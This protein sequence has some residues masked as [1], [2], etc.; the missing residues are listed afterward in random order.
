MFD[1]KKNTKGISND[2]S[3]LLNFDFASFNINGACSLKEMNNGTFEY[4]VFFSI[5]GFEDP[6]VEY[7]FSKIIVDHPIK[8]VDDL[9]NCI[10]KR[11]YVTFNKNVITILVEYNM[12]KLI[13]KA[14][15]FDAEV[16]GNEY[17]D[18][19]SYRPGEPWAKVNRA[20]MIAKNELA[21]K[22]S[23]SR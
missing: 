1:K 11:G 23:K 22:N 5:D 10:K 2:E 15:E 14:I 7:C 12:Q 20:V 21:D 18:D 4:Y 9:I 19:L 3:I 17:K 16:Y 8:D 6:G 13:N